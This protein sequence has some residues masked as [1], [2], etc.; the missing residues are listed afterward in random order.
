MAAL[1][2]AAVIAGG[3]WLMLKPQPVRGNPSIAVLPFENLSGDEETG[4][5][6]AAIA[7]DVVTDLSRFRTIDVIASNSTR[8]YADRHAG[9]AEIGRELKVSLVLDGSMQR[10]GDH[11]RI[12]ANLADAGSGASLWSERWDRA[13]DDL[14]AVQTEIAER[15]I[16]SIDRIVGAKAEAEARRKRPTDLQAYDL[17]A[18]SWSLRLGPKEDVDKALAYADEA[19]SRDPP[20]RGPMSPRPG[21]SG[22][23]AGSTTSS[24]TRP[25]R[26][27]GSPARQSNSTPMMP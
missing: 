14:F 5:L 22:T 13:A 27:S 10:V 4:R 19:I 11:I 7:D 18:L 26:W 15:A 25:T 9:L 24:R 23:R 21:P 8:S 17:V 3:A 20:L 12:N 6:G 2:L 16:N 1:F